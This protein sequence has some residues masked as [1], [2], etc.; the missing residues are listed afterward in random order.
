MSSDIAKLRSTLKRMTLENQ[1]FYVEWCKSRGYGNPY[2]DREDRAFRDGMLRAAEIVETSTRHSSA[3]IAAEIREAAHRLPVAAA[4]A[5]P[6][7]RDTQ[8]HRTRMSDSSLYDEVCLYC[9]AKDFIDHDQLKNK[10]TA[11]EERK[12]EI[13]AKLAK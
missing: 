10:C 6:S 12:A 11:T 2:Q 3:N 7:F 5:T 4:T 13:D 1:D 8:G 9:G